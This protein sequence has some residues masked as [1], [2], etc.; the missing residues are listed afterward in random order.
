MPR[1]YGSNR[2]TRRDFR[3]SMSGGNVTLTALPNIY[4]GQTFTLSAWVWPAV[5]S[6]NQL[7]LSSSNNNTA[8]FFIQ[9]TTGLLAFSA[10]TGPAAV[11]STTAL[12][13]RRWQ[14]VA[15]VFSGNS[16]TFYIDGEAAGTV[17]YAQT[18][19][20]STSGAQNMGGNGRV[21]RM[22]GWSSALTQAQIR[23]DFYAWGAP[24]PQIRF[25]GNE[26]Q[27]TTITD[28]VGGCVGT[29][30]AVAWDADV[31]ITPAR[32]P[33][34]FGYSLVA[35]H[36][37]DGTN[38]NAITGTATSVATL[39]GNLRGAL[40][41]TL[42]CWVKIDGALTAS[43]FPIQL[44]Q[45]SSTTGPRLRL[46]IVGGINGMVFQVTG[47][48][49]AGSGT[50]VALTGVT[51][52]RRI[53]GRW[54]HIAATIDYTLNRV[55]YYIDGVPVAQVNSAMTD[56]NAGSGFTVASG[57][58]PE[59]LVGTELVNVGIVGAPV[60]ASLKSRVVQTGHL[61]C[62]RVATAEE[63]RALV[64][65]GTVPAGAVMRLLWLEGLGSTTVDSISAAS[66]TIQRFG[67]S[68]TLYTAGWT[69]DVP[70]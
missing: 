28:D 44:W 14:H 42:A 11:V 36:A 61:V 32:P 12:D 67:S 37:G 33:K 29:L 22:L 34:Q 50:F 13:L 48:M 49:G 35:L 58:H 41:L 27:G 10:P 15:V 16:V 1:A 68:T 2:H 30:A 60:T 25:T 26:G 47:R 45:S 38:T 39:F 31:P 17:A 64:I 70:K 4:T 55:I 21:T 5:L 53:T 20:A 62:N 52:N 51:I 18:F 3:A 40:G 56:G 19:V 46:D 54:A 59:A 66:F 63:L 7:L 9:V 65:A 24:P 57:F 23:A 43:V 8:Q 69:G 6:G